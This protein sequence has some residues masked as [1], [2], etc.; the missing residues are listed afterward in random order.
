MDRKQNILVVDD[1]TVSRKF[2]KSLLKTMGYTVFQAEDG[3]EA[4]SIVN[5]K[6]IDLVLMDALMPEMDGFETTRRIRRNEATRDLPIIMVTG[7]DDPQNRIKAIETGV[8]DFLTK[9]VDRTELRVRTASLIKMKMYQDEIKQHRIDLESKVTERTADLKDAL[10]CLKRAHQ[11]TFQ[12]HIDT[13][14][15]LCVAAEY[16]DGDT[17]SHIKR[18]GGYCEILATHLG[19]PS[20]EVQTIKIASAMHDIGKI[21]I[22]DQILLK[23][24]KLTSEEWKTMRQH[25]YIG[26]LILKGSDSELLKAGEIIASSHHEKWDGSGYPDGLA[27]HDIPLYGRICALAD[28]F[29]A[30]TTKRAYK[31][32]F[33]NEKAFQILKEGRNTA[34]DPDLLDIFF[35]HEAEILQVQR[36]YRQNDVNDGMLPKP[37]TFQDAKSSFLKTIIPF[38]KQEAA[39]VTV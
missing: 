15:R 24:G 29:D 13:I 21:G 37:D 20:Q 28:T 23:P 14:R 12:A 30:L 5:D 34:F 27:G 25:C 39:K 33:E 38:I 16:K 1:R 7:L 26:A 17:G 32:A 9:P 19:M 18:V 31:K 11:K 22:P 3:V 6:A 35:N 4:L 36:R 10:A 2:L 8:N